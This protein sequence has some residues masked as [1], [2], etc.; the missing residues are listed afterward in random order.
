MRN[1][2]TKFSSTKIEISYFKQSLHLKEKNAL[3]FQSILEFLINIPFFFLFP[4]TF[5]F[6]GAYPTD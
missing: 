6:K 4:D 1:I 5:Q 3:G 2:T